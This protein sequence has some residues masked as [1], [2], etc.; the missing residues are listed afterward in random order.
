MD[1]PRHLHKPDG[2]FVVCA[3]QEQYEQLEPRGWLLEPPAHVE[4]PKPVGIAD[5]L[6]ADPA[7]DADEPA[8]PT[9][10]GR[11]PKAE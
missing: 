7:P 8:P 10:R 9:K 6:A 4:Q 2:Y 11:K 3:S 1:F 5:A